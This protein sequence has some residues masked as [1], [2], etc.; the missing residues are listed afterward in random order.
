MVSNGISPSLN[1][2]EFRGHLLSWY[3]TDA[4]D[5]PWRRTND[6]YCIWV[7]EIML[8]QTKVAAVIEHYNEFIRRFPD[9][10]KLA[11]ARESSV[12]AV[13][14]GLGYYRRARM[15]RQAAKAIVRQFGGEFPQTAQGWRELPGIGRYTSAAIASI[16]FEEP[17]AV[18]DGNVER[19][20]QR[21]LGKSLATD[22]VWKVAEGLLDRDRP[23]DFNQAMMELG[24][25]VCTPRAP[26]C[27]TCPVV[28]CCAT[29]GEMDGV[30]QSGRQLKRDIHYSLHFRNDAI[31]L[32][33]RPQD[34][35]LMASMWELPELKI[36]G[37][38]QPIVKL[39]E[40]TNRQKS[41]H[42]AHPE[43]LFTLRHSI[44]VTDYT[45]RVWRGLASQPSTGK[46]ISRSRVPKL[47]LTGLSRKIL[48]A[49]ALL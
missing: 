12:L 27:L 37:D 5:L 8:Q 22:A 29:R 44:T 30:K 6:P 48:R 4:R 21:L 1:I 26:A 11:A 19:L 34:A 16:A 40:N 39:S 41:R 13:W 24:A 47:A 17:V 23:G 2:E 31:L 32:T 14:S 45:V 33:Q 35:S 36:D 9:V 15:M 46:W 38:G 28:A 7:S 42:K 49:A 25:T 10:K 43:L 20:V 3:E 18:V